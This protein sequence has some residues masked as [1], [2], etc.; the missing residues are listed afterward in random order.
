MLDVKLT[1]ATKAASPIST[2]SFAALFSNILAMSSRTLR[3]LRPWAAS[4][5]WLENN[6]VLLMARRLRQYWFG[7]DHAMDDS[8]KF[9]AR[10]AS[11]IFL[12]ERKRSF[13]WRTSSAMAAEETTTVVTLP[14][15]RV[16]SGP[17]VLASS[18]SDSWGLSPSLNR[19]PTI[20]SGVGPGGSVG[21]LGFFLAC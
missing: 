21:F 15:F 18:V 7:C 16:M 4:R 20:G 13:F 6:W 3:C 1:V 9:K 10:V 2:A 12:P 14:S 17:C 5:L 11:T 19:L 8:L